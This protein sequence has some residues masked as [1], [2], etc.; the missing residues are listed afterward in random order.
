MPPRVRIPLNARRVATVVKPG[1]YCDGGGLYLQV[2]PTG[3]KSWLFRYT[4]QGRTQVMGLGPIRD[5][6]L[7]QA[8]LD[9]QHCRQLLRRGTDPL[10]ARRQTQQELVR[11]K[12]ATFSAC[13]AAYIEVHAPAWR[14]AKHQ[15][16]WRATLAT[17][18]EATF[19]TVPVADVDTPWVLQALRP[20][21][22]TKTET[23]T[24]VRQRI[25][26]VLDWATA[27]G[28]RRGDNPARWRGHLD[29]LLPKPAKLRTVRHH[30]A[31]PFVELGA[32]MVALRQQEG[33]GARALEFCILTATRTN[34]VLGAHWSEF[35]RDTALWT[36]P[37][38]RM[39][40][41][42]E[43]RVPLSEPAM[44]ILAAL[45]GSGGQYVFRSA[46]SD[47]PLSNMAMLEV[48]RR[49]G[50]HDLTVHGFRSTFRDWAAEQ[51]AFPREVAEAALA[52]TLKDK[53]EAAYRRG[54]LLEKRSRLMAAWAAYAERPTAIA[55]VIPLSHRLDD[56][57]F[58]SG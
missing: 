10:Q 24:R 58:Q 9:A 43:H 45:R 38:E 23:A 42:R 27:H 6:S 56:G 7:K 20:I 51:T 15:D 12:S 14:N 4:R 5:V 3:T 19:G 57:V 11:A 35:D 54:D 29:Q 21:W 50:R 1:W 53:S 39:K 32:F 2:K 37:G 13:C 31:L 34:E 16:Q 40:A 55:P 36:I 49:M 18:A 17:Y 22:T 46:M 30:P 25:E 47:R 41:A 48:L 52:H 28:Y 8:R 44:R 33:V 26:A